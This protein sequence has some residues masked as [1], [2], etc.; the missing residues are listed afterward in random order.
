[1]PNINCL[2]GLR[3]PRCQSAEPFYITAVSTFEVWDNG[4]EDYSGV[5]WEGDSPCTCKQC[6]FTATVAVFREDRDEKRNPD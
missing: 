6:N 3:C 2:E 1:M 5:E 4:T